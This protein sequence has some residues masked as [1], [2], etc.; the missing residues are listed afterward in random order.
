MRFTVQLD[1]SVETDKD[2]DA[3]DALTDA[4]YE[5]LDEMGGGDADMTVS[6]AHRT[7][8]FVLSVEGTDPSEALSAAMGNVRTAIHAN[9][10]YT[11][12]W[13]EGLSHARANVTPINDREL[14][15]S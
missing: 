9:G 8:N 4:V 12:G 1:F 15:A 10:G 6:L 7:V 2:D 13:D 14:I 11:T 5:A 3:F